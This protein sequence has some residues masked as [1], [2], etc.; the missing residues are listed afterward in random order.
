VNRGAI[1]IE[2]PRAPRRTCAWTPLAGVMTDANSSSRF[3]PARAPA[4]ALAPAL[5]LALAI[6]G[7]LCS[8]SPGPPSALD[9]ADAEPRTSDFAASAAPILRERCVRCH[10][11]R[12]A[13]AGVDL[14]RLAGNAAFLVEFKTWR[15]VLTVLEARA[16]PP[17]DK[18]QPS[19]DERRRLIEVVRSALDAAIRARA[20]DPGPVVLRRLTSAE[21]EY[22][23]RDLTEVD[24]DLAD[25]VVGDAVGG[26][27]FANVGT[28]QF[29]ADSTLERYLVAARKVASHAIVGAGPLRFFEHPDRAGYELA[30]I[31][32]IRTIYR[33]FGFRTGAGEDA[34][35]F[36]LDAYPKAFHVAW[37]HRHRDALG[38]GATPLAAL[39]EEAG[40]TPRFAEHIVTVLNRPAPTFPTAAIVERW[41]ALPH[42]DGSRAAGRSSIEIEARVGRECEELYVRLHEL[43][44]RLAKSTTNDEEAAILSADS[45][46]GSRRD[47]A[48][49]SSQGVVDFALELPQVSHRE[50]APS[51]RDPIPAPFD[52]AYNRPERNWFHAHVKYHR[53]DRFL[54]EHILETSDDRRRLDEA[55]TDL[56]VSFDY[57][58]VVLGFI[59]EKFGLDLDSRSV[60]DLTREQVDRIPPASR[61]FVET[62]R[63]SFA[64]AHEALRQAEPG[65]VDDALRFAARAWRRPLR[66][67]EAS[68]LRGFYALLCREHSLDHVS[69]VRALLSR[70]LVAPTF[71]YRLEATVADDRWSPISNHE[72]ATRLSYFL[73]SSVPDDEL[74]RSAD[75]GALSRP[76]E[77]VRQ[78]RRML[79]DPRARRLA[80]E[81]F[82]QW[83][84]F[85]CFDRFLGVDALRFPELT[86]ELR[87]SML[88]ESIRFFEHI[89]RE[90]RPV[91][92]ILDADYTFLD[93]RL[94]AHY[95]VE[96]EVPLGESAELVA[97]LRSAHRGG[98]LGMGSILAVTSAPLRTS[99]V[100]R[101]DWVLRRILGTA[102]PPPPADA[103][104]IPADDVLGDGK[105]VR[106]RLE[107][108]RQDAACTGCHSRIDALGFALERFDPIGRWRDRY[109]D[110]SAIDTSG[111]LRDGT[112]I[113]GLDDLRGYLDRRTPAIRRNLCVKLLGYALGRGEL[114]TDGPLLESMLKALEESPRFSTIVAE[115]VE[116]EQFR[117]RRGATANGEGETR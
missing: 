35:P 95:G 40:I 2:A 71:L 18:P 9:D 26:E 16:M 11:G 36:G 81:F 43:Q 15:K 19:D 20:G 62:L 86:A 10:R 104:S 28:V 53:D 109:R 75:S 96:S 98:V 5:A 29:L 88:E 31:E 37:R 93:R 22:T 87:A 49:A 3:P 83:L 84:G 48:G 21:Y 39:A 27:G 102:V 113:A 116:S 115:I 44:S 24:L 25:D 112:E 60:A 72:L 100:K 52:N 101:G 58:D 30:A 76:D 46:D 97:G 47:A 4:I 17:A 65:H 14:E 42:P 107:A 80:T 6:A 79:R 105:S 73:W 77:L 45:F 61:A 8:A 103:G 54:V 23:I 12:R 106:Q 55:W 56:L 51:D 63:S 1:A 69:A 91:E 82:G 59:V 13:Q 7:T 68:E 70:I 50:A 90:D 99:P 57:H 67:D 92:E 64:A 66:A 32:R 38:L 41:N 111:T 74:R 108:H 117:S 33:R 110:E 89:V 34:K 78:S 85:Y 114:A 94:A